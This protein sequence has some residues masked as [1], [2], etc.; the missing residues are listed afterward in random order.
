MHIPSPTSRSGKRVYLSLWDLSWALVSPILALFLRDSYILIGTDWSVVGYYWL[1]SAGF[2]L[3]A[4]FVLRIQDGM[5]RYFSVHEALD[6]AEAVLFAELMTTAALFT[7]TRLD[8]IPRS[9][10]LIHGLLLATGV[11]AVRML[12]RVVFSA[13]DDI[14]DYRCRRERIIL[15]GANPFA[16]AFIQLLRAYAPQRQ[17]VIAVLDKDTGMVGRA[18]SGVQVFGTP[19]ELDTIVGE[20][21]I[22]GVDTDRVLVAGEVDTL[23]PT[24]LHEVERICRKRQIELCFLPRMIGITEPQASDLAGNSEPLQEM[25]SFAPPSFFQVKRAID[26]VASLALM[27]LLTPI[28][29]IAGVLV[30]LDVGSPVLF[31][32]E[33]LGWKG[34]SF[35]IYKFRTLR[36]PFDSDGNPALQGRKPS[37]IGRFLRASRI[38]E[39]PQLFNV[40]LGDMSLIG[41]R[42]LLPE[43]QPANASI[44]L[45]VRPGITGWAQVNGAKLVAK[46]DKE[47]LDNWYIRNAS[48]GVEVRIIMM[49]LKMMLRSYLASE[50]ANADTAQ[51]QKRSSIGVESLRDRQR[52]HA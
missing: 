50:E 24:L 49:T 28:F 48:L 30:L 47:R 12:V 42:P 51:V 46:E 32:Q 37:A 43:D 13:S 4:F 39:L 29:L 10:P 40:L 35:L 11:I 1:L 17:S 2:T 6:I 18:I 14:P 5:T 20:F 7:L 15:I 16:S 52:R 22:H 31:W 45:S 34:R 19:Q 36:A 23:S 26:I 8:G 3:L 25:P 21:A 27:V 41:P 33:R 38:D 9:M 44:R